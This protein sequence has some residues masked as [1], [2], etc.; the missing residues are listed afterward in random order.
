MASRR[1]VKEMSCE[2]YHLRQYV[3]EFIRFSRGG[4]VIMCIEETLAFGG[5]VWTY[6]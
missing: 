1:F 2:G 5:K 6:S 4:D 3:E